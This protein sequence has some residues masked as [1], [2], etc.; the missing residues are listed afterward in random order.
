MILRPVITQPIRP[1]FLFSYG[2]FG[3]AFGQTLD[4]TNFESPDA[5]VVDQ[6]QSGLSALKVNEPSGSDADRHREDKGF[7]RFY[8]PIQPGDIDSLSAVIALGRFA[9]NANDGTVTLTLMTNDYNPYETQ[10]SNAPPVNPADP[11]FTIRFTEPATGSEYEM[12]HSVVFDMTKI[13]KTIYGAALIAHLDTGTYIAGTAGIKM[14][15][16]KLPKVFPVIARESVIDPNTGRSV[17]RL[18]LTKGAAE[19][20]GTTYIN[21]PFHANTGF[22]NADPPNLPIM[23]Q[24]VGIEGPLVTQ[25][26]PGGVD[27]YDTSLSVN[28]F[29][30][31]V[32]AFT[33]NTPNLAQ[34]YIEVL[35]FDNDTTYTEPKTACNGFCYFNM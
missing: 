23:I 22:G 9:I 25:T 24:N 3:G 6:D 20:W 30:I 15:T 7:L 4:S 27:H 2:F 31:G 33:I 18:Y 34:D 10:Y 1:R 32:G 21:G 11:H 35:R 13:N 17:K 26:N 16:S 12:Q 14:R 29:F 28:A 19:F 8:D 5:V